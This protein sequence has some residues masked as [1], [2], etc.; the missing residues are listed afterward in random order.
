[1]GSITSERIKERR[2][3]LGLSVDDLAGHVGRNRATIYRY[4]SDHVSSMSLSLLEPIAEALRTTPGY[5]MGWTDEVGTRERDQELARHERNLSELAP[6]DRAL[7]MELADS[8]ASK[9][10]RLVQ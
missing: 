3:A 7:V 8:L 5:L 6:R 9:Q 4:E 2:L 1:M 10:R